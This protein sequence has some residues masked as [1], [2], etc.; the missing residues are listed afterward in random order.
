VEGEGWPLRRVGELESV[1]TF[2]VEG[3]ATTQHREL[4]AAVGEWVRPIT[5]MGT[6]EARWSH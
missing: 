1:V 5:D 6:Q 2:N 4:V 3:D